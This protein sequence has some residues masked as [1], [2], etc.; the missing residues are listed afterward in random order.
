MPEQQWPGR[1]GD[2]DVAGDSGHP[3]HLPDHPLDLVPLIVV[4]HLAVEAHPA[5]LHR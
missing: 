2:S 1:R 4:V 5:A 3:A